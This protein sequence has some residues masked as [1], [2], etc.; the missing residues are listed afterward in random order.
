MFP[1]QHLTKTDFKNDFQRDLCAM[2]EVWRLL[3]Q[4]TIRWFG[5]VGR[6]Y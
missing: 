6:Q 4:G 5:E 3:K 1:N 2:Q